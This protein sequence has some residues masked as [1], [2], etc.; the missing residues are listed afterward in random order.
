[1][2]E[3]QMCLRTCLLTRAHWQ[4]LPVVPCEKHGEL[5]VSVCVASPLKVL[6]RKGV[7]AIFSCTWPQ[8]CAQCDVL[9]AQEIILSPQPVF[10]LT[11]QK[12]AVR[13]C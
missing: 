11:E 12:S 9:L 8:E 6:K 3:F 5:Q 13:R 2:A 1:M 4:G 7:L 10:I